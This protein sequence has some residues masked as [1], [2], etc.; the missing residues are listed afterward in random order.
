MMTL[1]GMADY[2]F[3]SVSLFT[4]VFLGEIIFFSL[5]FFPPNF[6][7][8]FK[9]RREREKERERE[10]ETETKKNQPNPFVQM[11]ICLLPFQKRKNLPFLTVLNY[12]LIF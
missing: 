3:T 10:R 1:Q 6:C 7:F 9:Q 11:Q 4:N 5:N 12:K 2:R 8:F